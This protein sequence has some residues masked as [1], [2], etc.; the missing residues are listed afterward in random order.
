[1][2]KATRVKHDENNQGKTSNSSDGKIS[3]QLAR[4][5]DDQTATSQ[6]KTLNTN[7]RQGNT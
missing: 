6:S 5:I 3:K 4:L 2:I 1:M 7:S